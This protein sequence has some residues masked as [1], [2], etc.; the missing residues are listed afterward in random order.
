VAADLRRNRLGP[1]GS[2]GMVAGAAIMLAPL[3]WALL[4]SLKSNAALVGH[5]EAALHGPYTLE[6]YATIFASSLTL[7]W[8]LNSTIVAL[9]Q[10]LGVLVLA[11][12]AGYGFSRLDFPFRRTLYIIVLVGLAVPSQAVILPQHQL[13]AWLHLH[14]SYPG[15]I[16]PGLIAPF[17]VFFMTTYMRGIPRELVEADMLVGASRWTIFW[18]VI[19]PL[20]GPAQ[21]TLAVFT[22]LGAWNDYWWPLI[23]ATRSDMYTLT[24]GLAAAQMNYAQTSGLG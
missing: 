8:L 21:S 22:F 4:L 24:L 12:L 17:G 9:G 10:T 13:F 1:L 20:T 15:L 11:S 18:K 6:N 7:R 2:T 5:S 14:N 3:V 19:L 23:S 16:L